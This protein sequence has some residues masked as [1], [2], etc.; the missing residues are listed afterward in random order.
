MRYS[1]QNFK[2]WLSGISELCLIFWFSRKYTSY[3]SSTFCSEFT[4]MKQCCKYLIGLRYKL[5]MM[6]IPYE[7]TVYIIWDDHSLSCNTTITDST[8]KQKCQSISYHLLM[9]GQLEISGGQSI[10]RV[11]R[12]ILLPTHQKASLRREKEE[13][14]E[15]SNPSYLQV[16][17]CGQYGLLGRWK[18]V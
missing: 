13:I 3:E 12:I 7:G 9:K 17:N 11:M 2:D 8:L 1:Y 15:K 16:H 18:V 4:A 6:G 5:R 14:C 10:S